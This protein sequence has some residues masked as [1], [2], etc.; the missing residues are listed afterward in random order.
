MT[1]QRRRGRALQVDC[2]DYN[3]TLLCTDEAYQKLHAK[4]VS[5]CES[6]F[7]T[8]SGCPRDYDSLPCG[9]KHDGLSDV[10]DGAWVTI[11]VRAE[12]AQK[13]E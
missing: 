12:V 1:I 7:G 8:D 11:T 5:D 6:L 2:V 13:G 9:V 10:E 3:C 4:K